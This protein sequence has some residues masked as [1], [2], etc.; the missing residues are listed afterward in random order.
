MV[1]KIKKASRERHLLSGGLVALRRLAQDW[2]PQNL[3]AVAL[4]IIDS[5]RRGNGYPGSDEQI[6][7]AK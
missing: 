3:E 1:R 5:L 4:L 2:R 7:G 6:F